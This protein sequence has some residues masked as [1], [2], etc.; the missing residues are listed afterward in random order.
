MKRTPLWAAVFCFLLFTLPG[1]FAGDFGFILSQKALFTNGELSS[2]TTEYSGTVM[3]WFASPLG[4]KADLYLSGGLSARYEDE[5][6]KPL[7]EIYRFEAVYSP[8]PD[9][10]LEAGRVPF[11]ESLSYVAEGLFDGFSA[12][13]NIGGGRLNGGLFYTGLLYKKAVYIYMSPDDKRDFA[14]KD[15]YF[16]SRRFLGGINWEKTSVFDGR[17]DLSLSGLCQFDLN[18]GGAKIHS[19]YFEAA[20]TMPLGAGFNTV[21]GAVIEVAE[22]PGDACIAFALSAEV[23]WFLPGAVSSLLTLTGR[24]SSGDWNEGFGAFIPVTAKAQGRVLRPMLS[25]IAFVE[26]AY[27]ARLYRFLSAD[28]SGAYYFRTDKTTYTAP[29]MDTD[30][31]SPLLGAELYGGLSWAPYSDLLLSLGAG[32]FLPQ[33]GKVFLEKAEIQYRVELAASISL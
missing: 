3:P 4:D 5:E 15:V 25:G 14:D 11:K 23:Q 6:W 16:A 24:F 32:I 7:P 8:F 2:G 18:G 17:S 1:A 12:G 13:L 21:S 29:D 19:Q 20:F 27:T 26:A 28:V 30:S 33:A 10:R 31:A 9:L 22:K